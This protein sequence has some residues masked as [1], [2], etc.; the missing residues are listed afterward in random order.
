MGE[1]R[2]W[3]LVWEDA[4][5]EETATHSSVLAWE[6]PRT[7][8]PGGLQSSGSQRVRHGWARRNRQESSILPPKSYDVDDERKP[9][10]KTGNCI[11]SHTV[12]SEENSSPY[13]KHGNGFESSL[14]K[15]TPRVSPSVPEQD[16]SLQRDYWLPCS[17]MWPF[18][19]TRNGQLPAQLSWI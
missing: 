17:G 13:S 15:N 10:T 5:E 6:T 18:A 12:M 8:E 2:V 3:S 16:R 19:P 1:T 14:S 9:E 11:R 4:L 7:E